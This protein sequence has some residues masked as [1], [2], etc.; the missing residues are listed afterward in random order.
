MR[1]ASVALSR[2]NSVAKTPRSPF[3]ASSRLSQTV[4]NSKTVG[5]WNFRPMPSSAISASSWRV[6]SMSPSKKTSPSSGRVLPVMTSII[7]VLPAPFGPM[8]ARISP[9]VDD[10][11]Q[12]VQ[13]LEAVEGDGDVVEIEEAAA[14]LPRRSSRARLRAGGVRVRRTQH[15]M[16]RRRVRLRRGLLLLH[17]LLRRRGLDAAPPRDA[18]GTRRACAAARRAAARRPSRREPSGGAAERVPALRERADDALR[19]EQRDGDEEAAEH[20]E[21]D[22]RRARR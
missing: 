17:R 21:P 1:A 12:P 4:W 6:R 22:V 8:M 7:V 2:W 13:R 18:A 19:Q 9:C 5:F 10:E 15:Q 3:S 16:R 11:R 14:L 20:E